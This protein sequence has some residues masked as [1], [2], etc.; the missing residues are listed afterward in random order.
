MAGVLET[1]TVP[2]ASVLPSASL[3]PIVSSPV[4]RLSGHRNFVNLPESRG[5]KIQSFSSS[6]SVILRS[7]FGRRGARIACQAQEAVQVLPV[8]DA[9]WESLVM[10]STLPV[11][12]EFWA[13]WCGPCRMIHPVIDELAK[14]YSGKL[15]CYKVNTDESP[16]IASRYGIRS[17]P[18]VII[19]KDGEKKD[20]VIGAVPRSTLCTCIEKFL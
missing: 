19:F 9:T 5:L 14:E 16:A 13:P 7:K 2:R 18:T 3:C 1:L 20:A 6:G 17:I 12:V 8:T 10:E 4:S 11:M 15:S